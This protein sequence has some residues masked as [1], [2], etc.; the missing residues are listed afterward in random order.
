MPYPRPISDL[1]EKENLR[2]GSTRSPAP[3]G[4]HWPQ[5]PTT[6]VAKAVVGARS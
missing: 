1:D 3:Q 2:R 5:S 4:G 6:R